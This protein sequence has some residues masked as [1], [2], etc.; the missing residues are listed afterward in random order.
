VVFKYI[1]R[2]FGMLY[3]EKAVN[4]GANPT[5]FEFYNYNASAVV[6]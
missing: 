3:L 1:L 4:P 6:G 2:R 5:T